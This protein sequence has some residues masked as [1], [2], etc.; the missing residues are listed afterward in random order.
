M[1]KILA[2]CAALD[3]GEPTGSTPAWWQLFKGLSELG[4]EVVAIPYRGQNLNTL[5]WR[6]YPNPTYR[7]G[8]L[9]YRLLVTTGRMSVSGTQESKTDK[10]V[11]SLARKL[12]KPRW[13][14]HLSRVLSEEAPDT[15]LF[16][17]VPLN[18]LTG[19]PSMIREKFG[20]PTY[21]YDGD[22]PA[23]L[24]KFGGFTVNYY[25]GAD[26]TEYDGF[27]VN[28]KGAVPELETLGA[29]DVKVLYW[30]ADPSIFAPV[31]REKDIDVFFYGAGSARREKEVHMMIA[32]PSESLPDV[33]FV[34]AVFREMGP[35]KWTEDAAMGQSEY[36][37]LDSF[38]Q[39][40]LYSCRSRIN[41]NIA[42]HPHVD[43]Y[44][45]AT[46]RPFELASM[47]CCIVSSPY[48]GMG[49]W[50][51]VDKEVFIAQDARD[52]IK[53]YAWLLDDEDSREKAGALAR[54][55]VLRQH[56]HLHRAKELLSYIQRVTS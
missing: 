3:L 49:E 9:A 34:H 20:I 26:L 56:T 10:V 36:H 6:S 28:S 37:Q 51:E 19:I 43:Y 16:I 15:V 32:E 41:L 42:R 5:W 2:L 8:K 39:Y 44:A 55:R 27:L 30:G 52:A 23:T 25:L 31:E 13:E 7:R 47:G 14:K 29:P 33:R 4:V 17:Q 35:W 11:S 40:R 38:V 50:F 12:A 54:E 21:Y 22:M 53:L 1:T 48:S 18:Q 24:P 45:S 46:S